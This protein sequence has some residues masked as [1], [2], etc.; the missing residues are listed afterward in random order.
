M[1]SAHTEKGEA[2]SIILKGID[3]PTNGET[4]VV[5]IYSN[6]LVS[7]EH[8]KFLVLPIEINADAIQIPKDHGRL[9]DD[10]LIPYIDLNDGNNEIKV[11]ATFR[12]N[13]K[14]VPTILEAEE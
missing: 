13:I 4:L 3:L 1:A 14:R 8:S 2:M 11:F 6:G 5:G 12:E 7:V 10:R 9:I